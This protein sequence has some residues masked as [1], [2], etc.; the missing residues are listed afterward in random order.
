[1]ISFKCLMR[2]QLTGALSNIIAVCMLF[3]LSTTFALADNMAPD[4]FKAEHFSA[5]GYRIDRY[6]S[7]TPK[8][9]AGASSITTAQLQQLLK[10]QPSTLLVNTL[11]V[12]FQHGVFI[13]KGN[14]QQVPGSIWLPNVGRGD[15]A[16]MWLTYFEHNL[17]R[18][19][20]GNKHTPVVLYCAA[21]CWMSWNATKRAASLGY[22]QLYWY[23][24]GVDGWEEAGLALELSV[25]QPIN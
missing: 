2:W 22:T 1:M 17:A 18:Q 14:E 5:D 15:A 16:P 13:T 12:S 25:P 4:G 9:V 21:D 10:T 7:P 11:P 20:K 19:T 24:N 3:G 23:R 8:T 6:R